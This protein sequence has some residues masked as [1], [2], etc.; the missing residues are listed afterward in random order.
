MTTKTLADLLEEISQNPHIS[1]E[2]TADYH[3]EL[4]THFKAGGFEKAIS[5][6]AITPLT[7]R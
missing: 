4:A 6:L 5:A 3:D 1:V 2:Q 7:F